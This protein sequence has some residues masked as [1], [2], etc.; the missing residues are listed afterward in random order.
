MTIQGSK[1]PAAGI[2]LAG[3]VIPA[4]LV[5]SALLLKELG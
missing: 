2:A 1:R 4:V 5:L 3:A